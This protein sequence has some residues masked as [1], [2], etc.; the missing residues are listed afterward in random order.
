MGEKH[1]EIQDDYIQDMLFDK[2]KMETSEEYEK[3]VKQYYSELRSEE[4]RVG[5][6]CM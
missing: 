1:E 4:R 6:E 3:I 2:D 5:K